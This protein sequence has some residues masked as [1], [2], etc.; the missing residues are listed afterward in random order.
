LIP[1]HTYYE[2]SGVY[3][4]VGEGQGGGDGVV[5]SG[6]KALTSLMT[7]VVKEGD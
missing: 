7:G 5:T 1:E 4:G 2:H 6:V 3:I